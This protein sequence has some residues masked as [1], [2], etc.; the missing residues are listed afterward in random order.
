M[1]T[2][3]TVANEQ[4]DGVSNQALAKK[5]RQS[6]PLTAALNAGLTQTSHQDNV[7]SN[8]LVLRSLPSHPDRD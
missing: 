7:E 2:G 6:V 5:A 1:T 8:T 3:V 4:A